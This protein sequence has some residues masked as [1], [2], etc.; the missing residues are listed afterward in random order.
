MAFKMKTKNEVLDHHPSSKEGQLIRYATLP[1][2]VLGY[3]DQD[4]TIWINRKASDKEQKEAIK[5]EKV[6]VKQINSGKL[7]FDDNNYY[8]KDKE[9][10]RQHVIPMRYIDTR[11]KSL[12]WEKE[13]YKTNSKKYR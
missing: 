6:H 3:T 7:W 10:G 8:W 13:A 9:H 5:H 12:P 2:Q 11:N 1:K 4:K